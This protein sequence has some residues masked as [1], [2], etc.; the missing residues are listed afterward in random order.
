MQLLTL[1]RSINICFGKLP[2]RKYI[3]P[4]TAGYPFRNPTAPWM[5]TAFPA[6]QRIQHFRWNGKEVNLTCAAVCQ[7]WNSSAL[8]WN[9]N[10]TRQ[11][12]KAGASVTVRIHVQNHPVEE[13][14]IFIPKKLRAYPRTVRGTKEWNATYKIRVNVEKSINHFKDSFCI[15]GRKT[16]N[17]KTLHANLLLARIAQLITVI[18]ADKIDKHQY[19]RNLKPLIA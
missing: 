4:L 2:L 7:P 1:L 17:E 14:S 16:R 19:I 9:E 10:T 6:V 3:F 15:A 12:A 13:C 8:K 18:V 5:K 11:L